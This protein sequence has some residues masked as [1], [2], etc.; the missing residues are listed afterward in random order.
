MTT[1]REAPGELREQA[2]AHEAEAARLRQLAGLADAAAQAAGERY[3]RTTV[4]LTAELQAWASDAARA[5]TRGMDRGAVSVS[6]VARLALTRLRADV[7]GGGLD[8]SAELA[9]QAWEEVRAHPGRL[10]RGMPA[11]PRAGR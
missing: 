9:A 4:H 5:V 8:L 6:A 10:Q 1:I 2:A 3:R 7:E 11:P